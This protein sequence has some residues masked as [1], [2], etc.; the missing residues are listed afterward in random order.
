M[1]K[2]TSRLGRAARRHPSRTRSVAISLCGETFEFRLTLGGVDRAIE[3]T[4]RDPVPAL[5]RLL[6][7]RLSLLLRSLRAVKKNPALVIALSNLGAEENDRSVA[8]VLPLSDLEDEEVSGL[9]DMLAGQERDR[10]YLDDALLVLFWGLLS[11]DPDLTMDDLREAVTSPAILFYVLEEALPV[12]QG[13]ARLDP[14][15]STNGQAHPDPTDPKALP[16]GN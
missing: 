14:E 15:S 7:R 12:L 16:E 1:A 13:W 4:G 9:V 5:E 2:R 11:D 6:R 3:L 8:D 10:D